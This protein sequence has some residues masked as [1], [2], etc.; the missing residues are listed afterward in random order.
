MRP[1]KALILCL[2]GSVLSSC[3]VI[4]Q[5]KVYQEQ[6]QQC[7]RL[8]NSRYVLCSQTCVDNCRHC[9]R[10]ACG[11]AAIN[12]AHYLRE[13]MI[14]GDFIVRQLNSYRDPLQCSKVTCDCVADW[15]TC[16]QS[17]GGVIHKRLQPVRLCIPKMHK[18]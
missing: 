2:L 15:Y 13:Q 7:E 17:C 11:N 18:W 1:I 16:K 12:L 10:K 6:V 9:T 3:V 4:T 8:C 5:N 14:K